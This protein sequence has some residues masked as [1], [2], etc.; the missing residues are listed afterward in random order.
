MD[1]LIE[2]VNI[3]VE[4]DTMSVA[5]LGQALVLVTGHADVADLSE[6][7]P[8]KHYQNNRRGQDYAAQA[9]N[10]G[11]ATIFPGAN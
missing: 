5:G 11:K 9:G 6:S 10:R 1:G 3:N 2:A 4:G 8:D 7:C